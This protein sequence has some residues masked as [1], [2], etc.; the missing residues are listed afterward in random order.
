VSAARPCGFRN[1]E[2]PGR[3]GS[4]RQQGNK[5]EGK[6]A[7]HKLT[8]QYSVGAFSGDAMMPTMRTTVT[9]DPDVERLLRPLCG[10]R[11]LVQAGPHDAIRAD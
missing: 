11:D 10:A 5:E 1:T 3:E 4:G 9:L 2:S 6:W 8:H 7:S